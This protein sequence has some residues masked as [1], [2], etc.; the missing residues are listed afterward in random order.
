MILRHIIPLKQYNIIMTALAVLYYDLQH[1]WMPWSDASSF[2][3]IILRMDGN[4]R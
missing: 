2:Q 4:V 3:F 1:T